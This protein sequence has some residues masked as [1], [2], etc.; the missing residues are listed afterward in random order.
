MGLATSTLG[1][2]SSSL[3][4]MTV[5]SRSLRLCRTHLVNACSI[6]TK[7][8]FYRSSKS[9]TKYFLPDLREIKIFAVM[10]KLR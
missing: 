7:K 4:T 1:T 8:K 3:V 9:A 2:P 5:L 6:P 10:V